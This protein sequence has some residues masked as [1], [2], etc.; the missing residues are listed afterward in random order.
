MREFTLI[1]EITYKIISDV[2]QLKQKLFSDTEYSELTLFTYLTKLLEEQELIPITGL[3][4]EDDWINSNF[5]LNQIMIES[6]VLYM[7]KW[8]LNTNPSYAES[9]PFLKEL[10]NLLPTGNKCREYIEA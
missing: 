9:S 6:L 2:Q 1:K 7:Y 5:T 8:K 10:V 4:L 3:L